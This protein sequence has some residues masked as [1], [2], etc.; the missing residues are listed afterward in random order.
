MSLVLNNQALLL[1]S[2]FLQTTMFAGQDLSLAD[3]NL[4][5]GM[6]QTGL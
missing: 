4:N 3:R 6:L 1:F 5:I 2:F